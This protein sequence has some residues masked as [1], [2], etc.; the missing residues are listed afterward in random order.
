MT[1]Y[2]CMWTPWNHA[3]LEH[4]TLQQQGQEII[5]NSVVLDVEDAAFFRLWYEIKVDQAWHVRECV[6]RL[7][8]HEKRELV[9]LADGRGHWSDASGASLA[10]LDGCL[11]IDLSATPFTNTLPI[12]R[13]GLQPGQAAEL[14]VA[15]IPVPNLEVRTMKQRYTCLES[16]TDGGLYRYES[17]ASGFTRDLPVDTQGLV[18][19]YPG[20]WKRG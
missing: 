5:I 10:M 14:S 1:E 2:Q 11:D 12:R 18:L 20:I 17:L 8:D 19:D 4:L 7:L 16:R 9:L 6:L 13:L 3:G 15:Y